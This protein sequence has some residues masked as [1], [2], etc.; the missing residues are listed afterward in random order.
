MLRDAARY[1]PIL[2]RC[3][4]STTLFEIKSVLR[5]NEGDDGRPIFFSRAG[6][7]GR[8]ISV[9]GAKID[10]IFDV[11]ERIDTEQLPGARA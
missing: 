4:V 11:L 1:M 6:S 8:V 2:S 10:N 9:L 7:F 5:Q 3:E